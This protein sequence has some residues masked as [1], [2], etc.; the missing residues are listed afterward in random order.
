MLSQLQ[1]SP[2][3]QRRSCVARRVLISLGALAGLLALMLALGCSTVDLQTRYEACFTREDPS[4]ALEAFAKEGRRS[5]EFLHAKVFD[6]SSAERRLHTVDGLILLMTHQM[7]ELGRLGRSVLQT[8]PDDMVRTKGV[9]AIYRSHGEGT[10]FGELAELVSNDP[11]WRVRSDGVS[12][13]RL[14]HRSGPIAFYED[15]LL[16]EHEEVRD[17]AWTAVAQYW[18]PESAIAVAAMFKRRRELLSKREISTALCRLRYKTD[19]KPPPSVN[20]IYPS[21][22]APMGNLKAE[23]QWWIDH[24]EEVV[25]HQTRRSEPANAEPSSPEAN[26]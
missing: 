20:I 10:N 12:V 3:G 9:L 19:Q 21:M 25:E 14:L 8:D 4:V 17:N 22:D 15:M 26:R 11:S 23:M 13:I 16:D 2:N 5:V 1:S 24:A 7:Q 6:V 18:R